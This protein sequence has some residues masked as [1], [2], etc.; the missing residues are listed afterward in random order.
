MD[1]DRAGWKGPRS[2]TLSQGRFRNGGRTWR[3]RGNVNQP[4]RR[5]RRE[6][7]EKERALEEP[8]DEREGE[9]KDKRGRRC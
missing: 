2:S 1:W 6:R 7:E 9:N 8:E 3:M 5:K 4:I